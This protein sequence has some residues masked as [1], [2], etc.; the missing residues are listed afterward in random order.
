MTGAPA[1]GS[2]SLLTANPSGL[3]SAAS[4]RLDAMRPEGFAPNV[5]YIPCRDDVRQFAALERLGL[6][7]GPGGVI[8]LA[9][10]SLP[11]TASAQSIPAWAI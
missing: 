9:Q 3:E 5:R 1:A 6:P 2:A 10:Q 4:E 11:L 7:V 8:C